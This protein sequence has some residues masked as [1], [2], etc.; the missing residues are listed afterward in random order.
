MKK[1]LFVL[2]AAILVSVSIFSYI[3]FNSSEEDQ[4]PQSYV[5]PTEDTRS[6]QVELKGKNSFVTVRNFFVD[7]LTTADPV[8]DGHYQLGTYI[9]PSLSTEADVPY[10]IEYIASTQYFIISL[11]REPVAAA[12]LEAE[13]FLLKHLGISEQDLCGLNYMVSVPARISVLNAGQNLGFS[14]CPDGRDIL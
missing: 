4:I 7:P 8:N 14:F 5:F 3:Y 10:Y 13:Q 6:N 1:I 2:A 12:R 11:R 9:D